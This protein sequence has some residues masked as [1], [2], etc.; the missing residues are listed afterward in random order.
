MGGRN[1]GDR[2]RNSTK[3]LMT[4]VKSLGLKEKPLEGREGL[5][6]LGNIRVALEVKTLT[7]TREGRKKMEQGVQIGNLLWIVII[8]E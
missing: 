8:E 2:K 4:K 7:P 5:W 1:P 3:T 6:E